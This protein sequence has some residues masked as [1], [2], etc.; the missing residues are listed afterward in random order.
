MPKK[1]VRLFYPTLVKFLYELH[2]ANGE[3]L[4][5]FSTNYPK[6]DAAF[7]RMTEINEA[8]TNYLKNGEQPCPK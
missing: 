6:R 1:P 8:I 2:K 3:Y 7:S 5:H 4:K